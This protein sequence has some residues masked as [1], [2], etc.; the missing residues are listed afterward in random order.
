MASVTKRGDKWGF[1][2][3]DRQ[4]KRHFIQAQPNTRKAAD[5]LGARIV[6]ELNLGTY[7]APD[8]QQTFDDMVNA[9]RAAH[10]AVAVRDTTAKWYEGALRN[11]LTPYFTGWKLQQ[12]RARHIEQFRADM[13][14]KG[15]GVRT[16]NKC[17]TLLGSMFRYAIKRDMMAMN[18]AGLVNKIPT[19]EG[20]KNDKLELAIL[21]PTEINALLTAADDHYRVLLMAAVLTGL[22]Q[23]ELLGLQWSDVDWQAR[24]VYVRRSWSGGRMYEP[25]T[26]TSR[27]RVPIPDELLTPLREWRLRCPKGA[28]DLVFP[29]GDGKPQNPSNLLRRGFFPALRRA[30]LRRI[31]FHDLRHTYASLLIARNVNPKIV[32]TLLGHSSIKVTMDVYSHMYKDAAN[33]AADD[34]GNFVFST[35]AVESGKQMVS[36]ARART[37]EVLKIA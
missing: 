8:E 6:S 4:R 7:V 27:R 25:K 21:T 11:H 22:R 12:I 19:P 35:S 15:K 5:S 1:D 37:A 20:E 29:N 34:L 28:L 18:P 24:Q 3:Y 10:L 32:S 36:E 33:S 14:A 30:G 23:G 13:V 26:K 17:L 9:Y 31:R 2:F 16:I